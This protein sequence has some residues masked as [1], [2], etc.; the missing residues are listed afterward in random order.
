M[1][2]DMLNLQ[3]FFQVKTIMPIALLIFMGIHSLLGANSS[4][5]WLFIP[6]EQLE[7]SKN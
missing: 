6:E 1:Q 3:Q 5:N 7:G 2:I 4:V